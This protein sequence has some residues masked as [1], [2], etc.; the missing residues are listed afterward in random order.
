MTHQDDKDEKKN[1]PVSSKLDP[2]IE[3]Q[4]INREKDGEIPCAVVFEIAVSLNIPVKDVGVTVDLM[5]IRLIKCQLGLFGYKPEKKIAKPLDVVDQD[6]TDAIKAE[7]VS[8]RLSC[9]RAWDIAS[10]LK[11]RKMT[12][13]RA[14]ES[15]SIKIKP[16]QLGAF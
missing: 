3:A 10:R 9:K 11:V 12:V 7:L 8:G 2:S 4:I 6:L 13:S 15:L 14:C 1:Q 16:C 5:N